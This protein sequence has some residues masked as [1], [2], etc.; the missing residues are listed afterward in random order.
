MTA[1]DAMKIAIVG[2]GICGLST[3][4][5]LRKQICL[6]SVH[7]ESV[8]ITIFERH[9]LRHDKN[10]RKGDIPSSGGGYGLAPNGMASLRRLDPEIRNQIVRGGFPSPKTTLKSARGWTIGTLPFVDTRDG[11]T[12]ACVM[13]LRE[14]V[15]DALYERI[16]ESAIVHQKVVEVMDGDDSA[17]VSLDNGERLTFDLVIGTD[18]VWSKTRR[19]VLGDKYDEYGAIYKCVLLKMLS[20]LP[21]LLIFSSEDYLQSEVSSRPIACQIHL[22]PAKLRIVRR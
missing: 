13:I 22:K 11:H 4:L 16:P 19:A 10:S 6:D 5:N 15:L 12:E 2:G 17:T 21:F 1:D 8:E 9:V 14:A 7:E 3:Y 18:G 20:Q